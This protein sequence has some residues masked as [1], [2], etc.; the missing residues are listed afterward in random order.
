MI[1]SPSPFFHVYADTE[2]DRAGGQYLF[3]YLSEQDIT[4]EWV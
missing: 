2:G 3:D 4:P 1:G